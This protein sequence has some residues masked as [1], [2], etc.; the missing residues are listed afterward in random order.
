MDERYLRRMG[1]DLRS[2]LNDLKRSDVAAASELG[3]ELEQ[4]RDALAGLRPL[5]PETVARALAT[6][7]LNERDLYPIQDDCQEGIILMTGADSEAS[8]R[9]FQRG[10]AD[11]YEYRDTAMS[12]LAM[13]RPEWIRMLCVVDDDDPHNPAVQWNNGHLLHQFTYFVGEINYYSE[14]RGTRSCAWVDTGDSV[15]GVPFARHSFTTRDPARRAFILA[16]TYGSGLVGDAQKELSALGPEV[17]ASYALPCTDGVETEAALLGQHIENTA[18]TL[19]VLAD[20]ARVEEGRLG[21]VLAGRSRLDPD[22]RRRLAAALRIR[23]AEL[24]AMGSDT[25]GGIALLRAGEAISWNYPSRAAADYRIVR[26]A[27]SA[28]H[29]WTRGLQ[30]EVLARREAGRAA[31]PLH[32]GLHQYLYCLGPGLGEITW[33]YGGRESEAV[34]SPGD[35]LYVKPFVPLRLSRLDDRPLTV[36]MLRIA[37]RVRLE[38]MAELGSMAPEGLARVVDEDRQWYDAGEALEPAGPA[39]FGRAAS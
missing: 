26:L 13:F 25:Q 18:L 30:I 31:A 28:L 34:L 16:L 5:P 27:G 21:E 23:E 17:A 19:E 20:T 29:S 1:A 12:R 9:V 22:E 33:R 10:G 11:Y 6:W 35:S 37:G 8:R 24:M 14:W 15:W 32:T 36:L 2:L 3:I 39:S 7:P 4:L 38:A